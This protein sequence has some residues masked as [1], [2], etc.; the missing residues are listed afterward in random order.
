MSANITAYDIRS[1]Q[2]K[3]E[4]INEMLSRIAEAKPMDFDCML[5]EICYPITNEIRFRIR[6]TLARDVYVMVAKIL[7]GAMYEDLE[8]NYLPLQG[9][10]HVIDKKEDARVVFTVQLYRDEGYESTWPKKIEDTVIGFNLES[11]DKTRFAGWANTVNE[12]MEH[13]VQHVGFEDFTDIGLI[14]PEGFRKHSSRPI[15]IFEAAKEDIP[16]VA[17]ENEDEL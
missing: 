3:M 17:V 6:E 8:I 1:M 16:V 4:Q 14:I 13:I 9:T 10:I 12:S 2:L 11:G 7:R 15:T 5:A